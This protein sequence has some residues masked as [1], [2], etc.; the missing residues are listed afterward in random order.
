MK[1]KKIKVVTPPK[2]KKLV[3]NDALKLY[4]SKEE[5]AEFKK[6]LKMRNLTIASVL[7]GAVENFMRQNSK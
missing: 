2:K 1:T 7:R 6:V 4:I 5:K 3:K